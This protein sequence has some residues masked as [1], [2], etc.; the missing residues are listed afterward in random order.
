M[1]RQQGF[2]RGPVAPIAHPFAAFLSRRSRHR[3]GRGGDDSSSTDSDARNKGYA[4][5]SDS[6]PT[7]SLLYRD[8][9]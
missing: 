8:S 1:R 3:P 7:C 5:A 4:N 9:D 2:Q 6:A